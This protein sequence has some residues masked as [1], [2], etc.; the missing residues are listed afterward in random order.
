MGLQDF[1][2]NLEEKQKT[3]RRE[4]AEVSFSHLMV[5]RW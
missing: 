4:C 5:T 2:A 1:G 3:V